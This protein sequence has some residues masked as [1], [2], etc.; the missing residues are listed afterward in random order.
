MS[1]STA[2]SISCCVCSKETSTFCGP[3]LREGVC[4]GFCCREH[5][6]VV[7]KAAHS[8]VCGKGRANPLLPP[9]FS[10]EE[11]DELSRLGTYDLKNIE[12]DE[13][14]LVEEP[15]QSKSKGQLPSDTSVAAALTRSLGV[16]TSRFEQVVPPLLLDTSLLATT[17]S[18]IAVLSHCRRVVWEVLRTPFSAMK[19]LHLSPFYQL[20]MFQDDLLAYGRSLAGTETYNNLSHHA[21]ILFT[22]VKHQRDNPSPEGK[23]NALQSYRAL[24]FAASE[25]LDH[26]TYQHAYDS[27]Q[28]IAIL[29]KPTLRFDSA[30]DFAPSAPFKLRNLI[31]IPVDESKPWTPTPKHLQGLKFAFMR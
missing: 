19:F 28:L 21:L 4:I 25:A 2:K 16:P 14:R 15:G 29:V 24:Q 1:A 22:L 23:D 26:K 6:K 9:D 30:Y 11:A 31:L 13:E 5:Q 27:A 3:C 17:Q 8:K 12:N 10:M 20:A 7:W 18:R